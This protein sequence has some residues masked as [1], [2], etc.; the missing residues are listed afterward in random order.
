M[1]TTQ[2]E[3][4]S[5][6]TPRSA[7]SG[8][9]EGLGTRLKDPTPAYAALGASEVV[10]TKV[11]EAAR[12]GAALASRM[13]SSESGVSAADLPRL[14]VGRAL[15]AAGRAQEAYGDLATR[16]RGVAERLHDGRQPAELLRLAFVTVSRLRPASGSAGAT[17]VV[18]E[19]VA[20]TTQTPDDLDDA[21]VADVATAA[22]AAAA[23]EAAED[24][25][26]AVGEADAQADAAAPQGNPADGKGADDPRG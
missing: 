21:T 9:R 22:A 13:R 25:A 14:A 3:T 2:P 17:V 5:A 4:D 15:L 1:T 20:V 16:G 12:Q 11:R 23:A 7:F 10:V 18:G 6:E 26:E 24:A 8:L 19:A